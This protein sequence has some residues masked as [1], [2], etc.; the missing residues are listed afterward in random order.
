MRNGQTIELLLLTLFS[1]S[2]RIS[3]LWVSRTQWLSSSFPVGW[4]LRANDVFML[5]RTTELFTDN[6]GHIEVIIFDLG[7]LSRKVH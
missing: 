7:Q 1:N 2:F 6:L 4:N 3:R 5:N